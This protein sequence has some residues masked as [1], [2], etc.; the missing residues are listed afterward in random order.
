[1]SDSA[2]WAA[3]PDLL[4]AL[5]D[6]ELPLLSWG[7]VDGYLAQ[8]EVLAV[9]EKQSEADLLTMGAAAPTPAEYMQ[10]LLDV[11][12]LHRIPDS[13][14]PQYRTRMAEGLRLI[15]NLRQ[16]FVPSSMTNAGWWN[17]GPTLVADYR[18][19]TTPRR[20][21]E[22]GVSPAEVLEQLEDTAAWQPHLEPIAS[23]LIRGR[24]LA[25][26][27]TAG[28]L[29]VLGALSQQTSKGIMICAGTGS[30]KTLAFY[31]P[32]LLDLCTR[33][34]NAEATVHTLAIYPRKEL[35]RD[36]ARE[37]LIAALSLRDVLQS[38]GRRQ[39]RIGLLYQDTP[40]NNNLVISKWERLGDGLLC[41]YFHCPYK[42][43]QDQDCGGLLLWPLTDARSNVERLVCRK[44]HKELPDGSV[45]LTRLSLA[46]NP[47]DVLF[48]TTEMLSRN[49]T[50]DLG[51]LVGWSGRSAPRLVLLDEAHTYGGI[52]GAQ[53]AL[54]LRRW[55]NAL[56]LN[57]SPAPS[58]VGLSATLRDPVTFFGTLTGLRDQDVEVIEPLPGEMKPIGREYSLLIRSDPVSGTSLLSTT[59]QTA[60]LTARLLDPQPGLFGSTAFLFTDDLDVNNRLYY[61]LRDAEGARWP[62]QTGRP[63]LAQLRHPAMDQAMVRYREGQGWDLPAQIGRMSP[64]G[65]LNEMLSAGGLRIGRTSSK[66]SGVDA[67]AD[68]IV[69]TA[70]L[71]V[72]FN[73]PRVGLVIQHKAPKDA[74]AFIQR[75]GR[76]GRSFGMRPWTVVV[77]SDY[78][79]DRMAYQSYEQLLDPEIGVRRLPVGN[80][81]VLKM[82]AVYALIDY[83]G[84]SLPTVTDVQGTLRAPDAAHKRRA[85]LDEGTA[86]VLDALRDLA[87]PGPQL[88]RLENHIRY[89]LGVDHETVRAVLWDEP[90]SI[91]LSVIPT[92]IRRLESSW[93]TVSDGPDPGAAPRDLLPEF[94]TKALFEPLNIPDVE[95]L[96][97]QQMRRP[98]ERMEIR[99]AMQEA[100][101][102]RVSRRFATAS[103]FHRT[104][105]D[106]G[107]GPF[108]ELVEPLVVAQRQGT[109]QASDGTT[110]E[111]LRPLSIQLATPPADVTDYSNAAQVWASQIVPPAGGLTHADIPMSPAWAETLIDVGF[112]LHATGNPNLVRRIAVGAQGEITRRIAGGTLQR[113]PVSLRYTCGGSSAGLGF[114]MAV[115]SFVVT[116]LTPPR[117]DQ[118]VG[119]FLSSP[120]WRT[121]AFR[122][123]VAEDPRLDGVANMFQRGWLTTIYLTSYVLTALDGRDRFEASRAMNHG[124]W[125]RDLDRV[126]N[127]VYRQ[128]DPNN[129]TTTVGRMADTLRAL[130]RDP[131]VCLVVEEHA[132]LLLAEEPADRTWDL[133]V[134]C[135][136]DTLAA[137]VLAAA[138]RVVPDAQDSDL[139][140]DSEL[141]SSENAAGQRR[142]RLTLSE[143]AIGGLGLIEQLQ[144][145]YTSDPRRFWDRVRRAAGPSEQEELDRSLNRVLAKLI[146]D[147]HGPIAASVRHFR[148][149][150]DVASMDSALADL[151]AQ[152]SIIDGYPQHLQVSAFAARFL[153][154]GSSVT[155]DE[156]ALQL[157]KA[158]LDLENRLGIEVDAAVIVYAAAAGRISGVTVSADQAFSLLWSRGALARRPGLDHWQPYRSDVLIER[159][160]LEAAV[161]EGIPDIDVEAP[162]WQERYRQQAGAGG[163]VELS[164]NIENVEQFAMALRICACL[165]IDRA[166]IRVYGR[167]V[168]I[169]RNEGRIR[170]R[171]L[172]AEEL[173]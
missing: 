67:A 46:A 69:A 167:L 103:S 94:V 83:L 63:V 161:V 32:A 31:L 137:A 51:L 16:L 35:L 162:D 139:I 96:M 2:R 112:A 172:I 45:A 146:Q 113:T 17:A 18:L 158:W 53:V 65:Q 9:L 52:H 23:A 116:A 149:A 142:V 56:Q 168:G 132:A 99:P 74:S 19:R 78:G 110:Y 4:N 61:D 43:D 90:R 26:F 144:Q 88:Q 39:V 62:G 126:L 64:P 148:E 72:G 138:H 106:P 55:R 121:L 133:V 118:R 151:I 33:P 71:E 84:R 50:S 75:R 59:I 68:V 58:F 70:S 141:D 8:D 24:P 92:A 109:W 128:Q 152:W 91:V 134:R 122:T 98:S 156:E 41:P 131:R 97:P 145:R 14:P 11:A 73:D 123:R 27:Q 38:Q 101:P 10:R 119:Q 104:W 29:S 79:R 164:A 85:V 105:I 108:L 76:A 66:D 12:A 44:C 80:R 49:S 124:M 155:R 125:G 34:K 13:S 48:T 28:A 127:A 25:R 163:A 115:D 143:T 114:E 42:D 82:Q 60:M 153:R 15:R 150:T 166:T 120:A 77:L 169:T 40:H 173:Q 93:S 3:L 135:Y 140:V 159:L 117:A 37:T 20:Y 47:P 5:E 6:L 107:T 22:R 81:F 1:M 171:I 111:V 157:M 130:T 86:R 165:P 136:A 160:L 102:G 30:G 89:A 87:V 7:V 54:L 170:A 36:Q 154:P 129:P 57:G 95:M 147:P 100:V 21:P